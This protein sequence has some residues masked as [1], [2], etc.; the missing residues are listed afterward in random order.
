MKLKV[1]EGLKDIRGNL[2]RTPVLSPEGSLL[3]MKQH[4]LGDTV[5]DALLNPSI[6]QGFGALSHADKLRK[7]QLASRIVAATDSKEGEAE[8]TK[9]ELELIKK[10][11]ERLPTMLAIPVFQ[12]LPE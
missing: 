9:D 1:T 3:D 2:V 8:V 12:L 7:W 5:A 4:V 10:H 11:V 6:E